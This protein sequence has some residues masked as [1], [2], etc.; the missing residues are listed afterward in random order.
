MIDTSLRNDSSLPPRASPVHAR[1]TYVS[2]VL[3]ATFGR[4]SAKIGL[5]WIGIVLFGAIF[6]PLLANSHP[7]LLKTTDGE[8]SSPLLTHLTAADVSLLAIACIA[9][10]LLFI[11]RW[12]TQTRWLVLFVFSV[13][14]IIIC[15]WLVRPPQAVVYHQYRV[16]SDQGSVA[17]AIHT[18]ITFS[19]SDR[20]RDQSGTVHPLAPSREHWL[21]TERGGADI[22]S[23]LIH[24]CRIAM[25]I[26]FIATGIALVIGVVLGGLMGYYSGVVDLIGMRFVE[27]AAAIPVFF[28]LL[29]FVAFFDRNLY[30]MMVIIG[31]TGWVGYARFI[32]AEFLKLRQ[33]DFVQAAKA[34]GL[35]VRSILFKHMLPNGVAPVLVEASFGVAAA[36]LYEAT[37]SFLGLGLV[38]EP[39][40]G[41]LL[42]QAIGAGG[43]FY[44]WIAVFPGLAIFLTVFAYNL[45]GESLRDAIDPYTKKTAA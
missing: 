17:W 16:M 30:V 23:R 1:H 20:L 27:I 34:C 10:V 6:A 44:W 11:K 45:I 22:L 35:P 26:G 18:P 41:Q 42:S 2:M 12:Q 15:T 9:C 7:L 19:P 4:I 8:L 5:L 38:D 3:H 21:G 39:S 37:L 29:S 24:A 13:L 14:T 33:Q 32:R 43:G 40:W 28:L 25:A 36:I 31:V